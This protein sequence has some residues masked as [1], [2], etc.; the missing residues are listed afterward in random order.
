MNWE[1]VCYVIFSKLNEDV[2]QTVHRLYVMPLKYKLTNI[3]VEIYAVVV[4]HATYL[5]RP[6]FVKMNGRVGGNC[7]LQYVYRAQKEGS[8]W[9]L[10]LVYTYLVG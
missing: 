9:R 4:T 10:L 2:G 3:M 1:F 7:C 6:A 8:P 5:F